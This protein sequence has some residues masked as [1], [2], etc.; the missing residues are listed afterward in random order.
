MAEE[1]FKW[2]ISFLVTQCDRKRWKW[3][4]F[5]YIFCCFTIFSI[6]NCVHYAVFWT[7]IHLARKLS[8]YVCQLRLTKIEKRRRLVIVHITALIFYGP[9][10]CIVVLAT[11]DW[12]GSEIYIY[13][14]LPGTAIPTLLALVALLPPKLFRT[15]IPVIKCFHD[16]ENI[17]TEISSSSAQNTV[18][19]SQPETFS[20]VQTPERTHSES[21][22]GSLPVINTVSLPDDPLSQANVQN[23]GPLETKIIP[24]DG[25]SLQ[26]ESSLGE[27]RTPSVNSVV[28]EKSIEERFQKIEAFMARME[29]KM[30]AA[31]NNSANQSIV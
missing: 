8:G 26:S 12:G 20:H 14:F 2:D 19:S 10:L 17:E 30:N 6:F 4:A 3:T 23:N 31:D 22:L 11:N 1:N 28:T 27:Y 24:L 7:P 16:E 21:T 25:V 29:E 5:C 18:V 13:Y 9:I 15:I